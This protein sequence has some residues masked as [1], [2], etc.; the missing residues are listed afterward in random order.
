MPLQ[1]LSFLSSEEEH[2]I[3]FIPTSLTV[4]LNWENASEKHDF[5]KLNWEEVRHLNSLYCWELKYV[6][7]NFL[8]WWEKVI[9]FHYSH[10]LLS[11]WLHCEFNQMFKK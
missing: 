6:T 9:Y 1:T 11:R 5:P 7:E 10:F 4:L 2:H 8:F 3:K